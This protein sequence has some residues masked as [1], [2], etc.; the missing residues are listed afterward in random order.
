M[1]NQSFD[2]NKIVTSQPEGLTRDNCRVP[3]SGLW[4]LETQ[5]KAKNA[6]DNLARLKTKTQ[7]NLSR[8]L[9]FRKYF[10]SRNSTEILAKFRLKY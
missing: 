2:T 6:F 7:P 3:L 10:N 9:N 8:L 5:T 1:E 4:F